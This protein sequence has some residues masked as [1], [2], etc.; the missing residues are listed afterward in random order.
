MAPPE[1]LKSENPSECPKSPSPSSDNFKIPADPEVKEYE[2]IPTD[3]FEELKGE[4]DKATEDAELTM[5]KHK[6]VALKA[7]KTAEAA[8]EVEQSDFNT[9]KSLLDKG[10]KNSK[11]QYW[12]EYKQALT[13]DLPKNVPPSKENKI[14]DDGRVPMDKR[15]LRIAELQEKLDQEELK[16]ITESK[17]LR[18]TWTV[19]ENDWRVAKETYDL[20]LCRIDAELTL[21]IS[22]G[23]K[24]WRA[25]LSDE[26]ANIRK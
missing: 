14:E 22:T 11:S 13:A 24:A 1:S 4:K 19:A 6:A 17:E 2:S 23:K 3:K 15:A 16:Y 8:Y 26:L 20:E 25:K 21:A 10:I 7:K 18:K 5:E 12:R 9:N